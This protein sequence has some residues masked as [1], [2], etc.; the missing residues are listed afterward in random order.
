M[1]IIELRPC[2]Q[3]ICRA[4]LFTFVLFAVVAN[5]V[6]AET[7]D[8]TSNSAIDPAMQELF[9]ALDEK[10][11][12]AKH[13]KINIDFVPGIVSVLHGKDLLARGVRTVLEALS[14]VPGIEISSN[15]SGQKLV[16]VRG[17]GRILGSSK[18]KILL[19][20][21]ALNS[22]LQAA[23]LPILL[24]LQLVDRIEMIRGPGSAIYGEFASVGVL[25]IITRKNEQQFFQAVSNESRYIVGGQYH[26]GSKRA[27]INIRFSQDRNNGGRVD[28]GDDILQ[29]SGS[30]QFQ[31]VSNSPGPINDAAKRA[32][33]SISGNIS[34]FQYQWQRLEHATGDYFGAA[35]ALPRNSNQLLRNLITQNVNFQQVLPINKTNNFEYKF[36]W[37][38]S[39]VKSKQHELFP[40]GMPKLQADPVPNNFDNTRFVDGV[41]GGPNYKEDK[42]YLQ[43]EANILTEFDHDLLIGIELSQVKQ[44]ETFAFRNYQFVDETDDNMDNPRFGEVPN[45]RYTGDKNWLREGLRRQLLAFYIQDEYALSSSLYLTTGVR[46]DHYDDIGSDVTPR[47]A[48]VYQIDQYKTFK[49]QFAQSFRPPVFI[50]MHSQNNPVVNGNPDLKSERLNSIEASFTFNERK[51]I[52]RASI[53]YYKLRDIIVND[54]LTFKYE[55]REQVTAHG[56]EFEFQ[57]EVFRNI[58][59]EYNLSL[60]DAHNLNGADISNIAGLISTAAIFYT[61]TPDLNLYSQVR[62][63]SGHVRDE[64]D[65]RASLKDYAVVDISLEINDFIFKKLRFSITAY[66]VFDQEVRHPSS[67][68]F[69][70]GRELETYKDDYPQL[71]REISLSIEYSFQ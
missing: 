61:P 3:T 46:Y 63:Q 55:N 15:N 37:L 28:A 23:S 47:I 54:P 11:E 12:V 2:V 17:V 39:V 48:S 57:K 33:L 44:G 59:F 69:F 30:P 38:R 45:Q 5:S 32:Y 56:I 36:G 29:S 9:S 13:T 60:I 21:V 49:V 8:A 16:I 50:E 35:N 67:R 34:S 53:Y 65:A 42:Y 19:D 26:A 25:N 40:P 58:Q 14:F 71:G 22:T 1:S 24:P 10:T 51:T 27:G 62:Y 64:G 31:N 18:I 52:A 41:L 4:A 43:V 6:H 20:G 70:L 68:T 7:A 66:N